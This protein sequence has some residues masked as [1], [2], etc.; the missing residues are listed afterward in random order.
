MDW[1]EASR[2]LGVSESATEVEIKEQYFYKAQLL[3]P[4]KNG[5]KPENI[6]KKAEAELA[7]VNQAY[8]VLNDPNNNPYK[9]PP[10]L[11]VEPLGI[12]FK[13]IEIGEKK[14]TTLTIRNIG[15]PY[16]NIWID[17]DPAPWLSITGIK[18]ITNERLPLEVALECIGIGQPGKQYTCNLLIKLENEIT[19]SLDQATVKIE[20]YTR[21]EPAETGIRKEA[22]ATAP[23]SNIGAAADKSAPQN[24]QTTKLGFSVK[25]FVVNFIGFA[26]LG[27]TIGILIRVFLIVND[28]YFIIGLI[29]Y[30]AIAFGFSFNH[31]IT[32]G[33]KTEKLKIQNAKRY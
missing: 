22:D 20:L 32:M 13:D 28:F 21:F 1:M 33:S 31:A 10:K 24:L 26:V 15:G 30:V 29:V 11:A 23:K 25:A 3:H 9:I 14:G 6:R 7:L 17:N 18:S 19:H 2:I 16:T 5:D 12:R 27:I 8:R 4:D